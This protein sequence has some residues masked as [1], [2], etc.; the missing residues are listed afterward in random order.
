M[1]SIELELGYWQEYRR[2]LEANLKKYFLAV[3]E[4]RHL[5]EWADEKI[6]EIEKA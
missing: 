4:V 5:I 1:E 3:Q 2:N 6:K